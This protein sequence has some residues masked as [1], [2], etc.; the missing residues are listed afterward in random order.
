MKKRTN[1]TNL[2]Y[3]PRGTTEFARLACNREIGCPHNC[4]YCYGP[5]SMRVSREN[6]TTPRAKENYLRNLLDSIK[7][8][9]KQHLPIHQVLL[10]YTGDCYAD[11]CDTLT[12]RTIRMLHDS[13]YGVCVLT[14]AGMNAVKDIKLFDPRIDCLGCTIT[15]FNE[16]EITEWEP[17]APHPSTRLAALKVFHDAGIF[18]WISM[19]PIISP[20]SSLQVVELTHKYVDHYKSGLMTVRGQRLPD[21]YYD[22]TFDWK[23]YVAEFIALCESYNKTWYCKH[24]LWEYMPD[25]GSYPGTDE[26]RFRPMCHK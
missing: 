1:N 10:E 20:A 12:G 14:K 18:T 25:T 2:I 26:Y 22:N 23:A 15:S 21:G 7:K 24:T 11:P 6:W 16:A 19:E 13:G 8:R 9:E 4:R 3:E 17:S 5:A